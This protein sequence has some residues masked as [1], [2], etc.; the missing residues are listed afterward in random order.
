MAALDIVRDPIFMHDETFR[1]LR[2]NRAYRQYTGLPFEQIIGRP[3]YEVFPLGKEASQ[4]YRRLMEG[5]GD[6]EA[7]EEIRS[8]ETLFRSRSYAIR[9]EK[10]NCRYSVHILE[11]ITEQRRAEAA[12]KESELKFQA[13]FE[14]AHD[15]I[16]LADVQSKKFTAANAR[17]CKMLGYRSDE[18][19][20]IGVEQ[21]HPAEAL[22]HVL[23]QFAK[24]SRGEIELATELPVQR[25]DGSIFF[26][27]V[28]SFPITL[29]GQAYLAGFFRD[30][31]ERKNS[32]THLQNEKRF[33]DTLIESQ[34]GI[35]CLLAPDGSILRWNKRFELLSGLASEALHQANFFDFIIEE[36]H[37]NATDKLREVLKGNSI[38]A[39][40]R[41]HLQNG[42]CYYAMTG[43][44]IDTQNGTNVVGI[45]IDITPQKQHAIQLQEKENF[46]KTVL[47]NL[48][49]GI[50]V[51]SV[52]PSVAFQYMND[53]FTQLYR[54]NPEALTHPDSFWEAVYEDPQFRDS[55]RERVINDC[56]S[57]SVEKMFW[58]DIPITRKNEPTTYVNA[59]NIPLP[60]EQMMISMVWDVTKR[61]LVEEELR[62]SEDK[63]RSIT[64][65]A[66]DAIVM[67]NHTGAISLWNNAAERMFGYSEDE[68]IGKNLHTLLA[69]E[70][71]HDM[72]RQG[73]ARFLVSGTGPAVGQT[74]E[75]AALRRDGT[76]FPI[77]LSLSVVVREERPHAIGIIRDI[78][79]RKSAETALYRA[80]RALRTLSA[81]NM[82]LVRA[83]NEDALLQEVTRI[84]V[85]KSGYTLATVD[86]ALDTPG[87]PLVPVACAGLEDKR[88]WIDKLSWNDTEEAQL[89]AAHAIRSAS[90]QICRD[91]ENECPANPWR[92]AALEQ[93]YRSNIALPL[94][95]K[96]KAFGVLS[97]YSKEAEPFNTHEVSLLEELANDLAY[98]LKAIRTRTEH[99]A[100][101]GQLRSSLEQSVQ[102]IATTLEARD[103]YTAG[104]Q[105]R[106]AELATAI[107]QEMVLD[108]EQ[109]QGIHFAAI[110]HDLGKINIPAEILAKPGQLN[111]IEYM[112]IQT[113]AQ[114]GYEILKEVH[115]PWPIA[116]IIHQ[117]HEKIDGSGYP[118]GLAGDEICL[119]ARIIAVADVMEA[120]SSH[121]PYRPALGVEEGLR[122]IREGR[123][124]RYD[125]EVVDACVKLFEEQAFAFKA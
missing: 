66:Q 120:I 23:E 101:A 5:S 110:I 17:M 59:R 10:G 107:A 61:K 83:E 97:I 86:Y 13:L 78:S 42:I 92:N 108:E 14:K 9:D 2:C 98:G 38:T 30:V 12:Q 124:I 100:Y 72:H 53:T 37:A 44:C 27:D 20:K 39:E 70:R 93:G 77:E 40:V 11:D 58:N 6:D 31:T 62:A 60:G 55:I 29:N 15:G 106:V 96:E 81:V 102:T 105:R 64:T 79:E 18:L 125:A 104:H 116:D 26:A 88:Y 95:E 109:I 68:A 33:N 3:Y 35:F 103:P 65:S 57:G 46:I 48:P 50:A 122:E 43:S 52:E 113:H 71:F 99:E 41:L 36:D 76:E 89:P 91:I 94:I 75:L 22:S 74:L 56:N 25:K 67:I 54:I 16:L 51:N 82:T 118:Q 45:G 114:A 1:I 19:T 7:E 49:V 73:F 85:E 47:D 123:A 21:I 28:N 117:H 84:I 119:E 24:Q 69:P 4:S 111:D 63:F 80:H 90:T 121:R 87:K 34:P 8:G 112:L 32:E 115:F